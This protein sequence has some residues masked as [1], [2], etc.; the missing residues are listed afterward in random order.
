M[1]TTNPN[2]IGELEE[3]NY[4]GYLEYYHVN[5]QARRANRTSHLV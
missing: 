2:L 3:S 1:M 5:K 4:D